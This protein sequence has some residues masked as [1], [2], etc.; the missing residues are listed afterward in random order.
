MAFLDSKQLVDLDVIIRRE[1]D[2]NY[3]AALQRK[4]S[5]LS[6]LAAMV[7]ATKSEVTFPFREAVVGSRYGEIGDM[8]QFVKPLAQSVV[9][10]LKKFM[11]DG[12]ELPITEAEDPTF[13]QMF[14]EQVRGIAQEAGMMAWHRMIDA[15]KNGD[16]DTYWTTYDGKPLFA[17]DHV[18]GPTAAAF[19]NLNPTLPLSAENLDTVKQKF[20]QIPLGPAGENL[21][22]D[23]ATYYLIVPPQLERAGRLILNNEYIYETDIVSSNVDRGVA[24]MIVDERLADD[25][26][27]WY[28]AMSLPAYKPFVH[29]M[30]TNVPSSGQLVSLTNATDPNVFY[31][32]TLRW[33]MKSFEE[34][35]PTHFYMLQKVTNS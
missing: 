2:V 5:M 3:Y 31:N 27:D 34:V 28:V 9:I 22:V 14:M 19:S 35:F 12:L 33:G 26:N 16:T 1:F 30:Q 21:P 29:I 23:T 32:D 7:P 17:S 15:L 8:P 25:A 24:E 20:K 18:V 13:R 6:A 10:K 4:K 11:P